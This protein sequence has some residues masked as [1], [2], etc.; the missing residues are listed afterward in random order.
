MATVSVAINVTVGVALRNGWQ[1]QISSREEWL[2]R[3]ARLE[4]FALVYVELSVNGY[5]FH[6]QL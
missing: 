2:S 6:N 1:F 5:C 3:V 4:S